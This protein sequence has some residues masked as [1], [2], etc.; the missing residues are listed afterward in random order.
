MGIGQLVKFLHGRHRDVGLLYRNN[1]SQG[2]VVHTCKPTAGRQNPGARGI[3]VY[4][5][6]SR[7]VRVFVSKVKK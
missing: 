2:M 1:N 3:L 5:I 6:M 7:P 4:L